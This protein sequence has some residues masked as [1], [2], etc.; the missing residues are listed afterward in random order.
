[1]VKRNTNIKSALFDSLK[2]CV[3][4][5]PAMNPVMPSIIAFIHKKSR[6]NISFKRPATNPDSSPAVGPRNSPKNITTHE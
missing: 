6:A 2:N 1:M 4:I 5:A 3:L